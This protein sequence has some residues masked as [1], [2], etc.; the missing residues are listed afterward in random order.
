MLHHDLSH[1][2]V[3]AVEVSE[4]VLAQFWEDVC[5]SGDL[6]QG[7]S[8]ILVAWVSDGPLGAD[9]DASSFSLGEWGSLF[10][11]TVLWG[12]GGSRRV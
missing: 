2:V 1:E 7:F 3:E 6:Y 4:L 10:W 8:P 11:T 12:R 5:F 9:G